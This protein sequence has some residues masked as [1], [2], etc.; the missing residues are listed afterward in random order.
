M[1]ALDG[2]GIRGLYT[3]I[4]LDELDRSFPRD[5]GAAD[6]DLGRKFD[7]ITGTS[8]GGI[9]ACA[10]AAGIPIRKVTALYEE[11]GPKIFR[12]PLAGGLFQKLCWLRQSMFAPANRAEPLKAALEDIFGATTVGEMYADRGIALCVPG[13]RMLKHSAKVFKTPH[14][15][16]LW[17]DKSYRLVDICL[18]TSAAPI[19]LP[20]AQIENA[21]RPGEM[22]AYADG[23]LWANNPSVVGLVEALAICAHAEKDGKGRRPI[24]IL[25]V[26]TSGVV[27][28]DAV[29]GKLDR[30]LAHWMIGVKTTQLVMDAQASSMAYIAGHLAQRITELGRPVRVVRIAN[31]PV[32]ASHARH[33][34]MDLATPEALQL[35]RQLG[36]TRAEE[37]MSICNDPHNGEGLLIRDIF[38]STSTRRNT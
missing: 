4:L 6:S 11:H 1:L 35:L 3:A 36:R 15:T 28:G 19:F 33:L 23:G 30:G 34:G 10:L 26:G 24:E 2:G 17:I 27:E 12:N 20:L 16:D 29:E 5:A 7:L 38:T 13:T 9:L 18:A 22:E 21:N 14:L 32:S 8:T 25:S 37:V 31:P